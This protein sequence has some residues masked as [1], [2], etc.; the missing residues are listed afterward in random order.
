M[1][2]LTVQYSTLPIHTVAYQCD[3]RLVVI[4]LHCVCDRSRIAEVLLY[5]STLLMYWMLACVCVCVCVYVFDNTL[6][7]FTV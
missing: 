1:N 6:H 2:K 5:F 3:D 7:A 4:A